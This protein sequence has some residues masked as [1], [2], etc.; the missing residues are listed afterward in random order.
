[1]TVRALNRRN[2]DGKLCRIEH[3]DLQGAWLND[4]GE[5]A[6]LAGVFLCARVVLFSQAFPVTFTRFPA[7]FS[8]GYCDCYCGDSRFNRLFSRLIWRNWMEKT[9][10]VPWS[11]RSDGMLAGMIDSCIAWQELQF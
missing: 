5:G 10:D 4:A 7:I 8:Y 6:N 2:P 11:L 9:N 1:M 3:F